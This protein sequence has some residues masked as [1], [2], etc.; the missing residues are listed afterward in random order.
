MPAELRVEGDL[1]SGDKV[2][3]TTDDQGQ[4]VISKQIDL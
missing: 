2:V 1:Q 4:I 3:F